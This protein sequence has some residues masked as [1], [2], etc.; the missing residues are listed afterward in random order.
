MLYLSTAIAVIATCGFLAA[1]GARI[2]R[3]SFAV[4]N[5]DASEQRAEFIKAWSTVPGLASKALQTD[6][7]DEINPSVLAASDHRRQILSAMLS[8]KPLS[9]SDWLSLSGLQLVTD[10]P[11]E[12]VLESLKM[13]VL[14]GPNESYLTVERGILGVT[15]WDRLSPELKSRVALDLGP[16]MAPRTPAEGAGR[17]K[18]RAVLFTKPR[19]VR[20][21]LREALL[22]TGLSATVV[23]QQLEF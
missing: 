6:L 23:E 20:N 5:I 2:V 12:Q 9:S 13:S 14:T 21:E 17:E 8:I 7:T 10:Q 19:W 11:I 3:F 15:L 18:F 4:A 22:A 1:Q 16:M